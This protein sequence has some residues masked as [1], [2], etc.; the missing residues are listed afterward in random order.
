MLNR[1][2]LVGCGVGGNN[3]E[4]TDWRIEFISFPSGNLVA[5]AVDFREVA[6]GSF[7]LNADDLTQSLGG[8]ASA[9]S[10]L[11]NSS[12]FGPGPAFNTGA[13]YPTGGDAQPWLRWTFA[14]KQRLREIVFSNN[15]GS[16]PSVIRLSYLSGSTWIP[17]YT[18]S[19][20][21][22]SGDGSSSDETK[23]FTVGDPTPASQINYF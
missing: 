19:G 3:P 2:F 23:V 7:V 13:W 6:S 9:S 17:L 18:W 16:G 21:T 11:L 5:Y 4:S 15:S 14:S 8:T 22:W 20:L 12:I 1:S 10:S